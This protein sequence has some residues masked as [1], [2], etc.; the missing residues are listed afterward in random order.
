MH[1]DVIINASPLATKEMYRNKITNSKLLLGV[2]FA[3]VRKEF[4][5]FSNKIKPIGQRKNIL[6]SFGGTDVLDL[7]IP[8]LNVLLKTFDADQVFD[9]V[10]KKGF[11]GKFPKNVMVHEDCNYMAML[12]ARS[13]LAI[14][15]AGSTLGELATLHVP[16][17][18]T[19]VADNQVMHANWLKG[20]GNRY[21][22]DARIKKT[23]KVATEISMMAF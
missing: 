14:S 13:G 7:T 22:I 16:T 15:A 1:A 17:I 9:V 3:M 20:Q 18:L 2:R 5:A 6:I 4:Q 19:V 12:M 8:V 23:D 11:S 10:V 21:I